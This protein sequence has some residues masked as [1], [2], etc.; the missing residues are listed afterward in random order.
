MIRWKQGG[1]LS[2]LYSPGGRVTYWLFL[3]WS[4]YKIGSY[5]Y[6]GILH[7][8][9][10]STWS[11]RICALPC[12]TRWSASS[13]ARRRLVGWASPGDSTYVLYCGYWGYTPTFIL[14]DL[15][16]SGL[17][18]SLN[19]GWWWGSM[20]A[21]CLGA[22]SATTTGLG[23]DQARQWAREWAQLAGLPFVFLINFQSQAL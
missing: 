23:T 1:S 4:A 3:S 22:G 15:V 19:V 5:T 16:R 10:D 2:V 21:K 9:S 20:I 18:F 8:I 6:H 11:P 12:R 17:P 13:S 7:I 14:S